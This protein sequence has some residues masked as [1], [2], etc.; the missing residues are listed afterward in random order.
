MPTEIEMETEKNTPPAAPPK[1]SYL[2]RILLAVVLLAAIAAAYRYWRQSATFESTD[3]AQVDGFIYAVSPRVG[4]TVVKLHVQDNQRV[5]AGTVL[6]EIDPR[7]YQVAVAQAQAD[8]AEAEADLAGSRTDIPIVSTTR[9]NQLAS[10]EAQV[11]E[12]NANLETAAKQV[13]TAQ[14]RLRS[15]EAMVRQAKANS[16]RAAGDLERYRMLVAKED[17]KSVV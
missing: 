5:E 16:D 9:S 13:D 7:D 6:L 10:N 4:G 12:A 11:Q 17:R 8:L 1:R 14:A 15:A 3:D 2:G